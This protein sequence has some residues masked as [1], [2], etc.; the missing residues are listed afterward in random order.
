MRLDASTGRR[1]IFK[2][3]REEKI[4]K[5]CIKKYISENITAKRNNKRERRSTKRHGA[6]ASEIGEWN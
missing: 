3:D 1:R 4:F 5:K 6:D 2:V